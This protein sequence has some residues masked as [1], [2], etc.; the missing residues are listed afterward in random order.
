MEKRKSSEVGQ[1]GKI[2]GREGQRFSGSKRGS[3][4]CFINDKTWKKAEVG[5]DTLDQG[6]KGHRKENKV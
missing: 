6:P 5:L 3:C 4:G 1:G 2:M